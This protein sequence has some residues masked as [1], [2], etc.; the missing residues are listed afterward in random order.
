MGAR[1]YT[2]AGPSELHLG[3]DDIYEPGDPVELPADM[4][5]PLLADGVVVERKPPKGAKRKAAILAAY[6]GL[7]PDNADLR[8]ADGKAKTEALEAELGFDVPAAERDAVHAEIEAARKDS[9]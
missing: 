8:T 1:R 4:A 9:K 3:P 7:D 2:I 5:A 6:Q